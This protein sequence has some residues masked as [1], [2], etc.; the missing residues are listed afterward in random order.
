MILKLK[1]VTFF[2][3][4]VLNIP[5][6]ADEPLGGVR[7]KFEKL[8]HYWQLDL[9]D[10]LILS[11]F[12]GQSQSPR[13][14][15]DISNCQFCSGEDDNCERDGVVE[16]NFISRPQ[17]PVLAVTCHIGAHSQQL[18]ILMPWKNENKA[19]HTMTGEYYITFERAPESITIEYDIRNDDGTFMQMVESWP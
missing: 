2:L 4:L 8:D 7:Y 15:Y 1:L 6:Y 10:S 17:E 9:D 5:V 12:E 14:Q 3:M 16:I 18:Q 13:G 11:L 19:I